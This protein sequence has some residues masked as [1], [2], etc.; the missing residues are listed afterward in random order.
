MAWLIGKQQFFLLLH[1]SERYDGCTCS[2]RRRRRKLRPIPWR[3]CQDG[4]PALRSEMFIRY[5]A[6]RGDLPALPGERG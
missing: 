3:S 5:A 1:A 2:E 4:T 6:F